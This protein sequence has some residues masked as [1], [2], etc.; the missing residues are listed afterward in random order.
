MNREPHSRELLGYERSVVVQEHMRWLNGRLPS[1]ALRDE[2]ADP[3]LADT[4]IAI[5]TRGHSHALAQSR[6]WRNR[7]DDGKPRQEERRFEAVPKLIDEV[8]HV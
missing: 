8:R 6:A 7:G 5:W 2:T 1:Q 3:R 4:P